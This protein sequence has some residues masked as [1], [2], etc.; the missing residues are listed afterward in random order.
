M[1]PQPRTKNQEPPPP[2][3]TYADVVDFCKCATT[4]EIIGYG[5]VLMLGRYVGAEAVEEDDEAFE[6][7]GWR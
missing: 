1:S 5:Y 7:K 6:G 2:T 3:A 4:A